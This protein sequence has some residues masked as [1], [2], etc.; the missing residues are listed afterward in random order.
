MN[1]LRLWKLM[2]LM[3]SCFV[4]YL[5]SFVHFRKTTM[6]MEILVNRTMYASCRQSIPAPIRPSSVVQMQGLTP[7]QCSWTGTRVAYLRCP[8]LTLKRTGSGKGPIQKEWR[9]QR[10]R[11]LM[12]RAWSLDSL[13]RT[14]T[15]V[16]RA[17]LLQFDTICSVSDLSSADCESSIRSLT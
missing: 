1:E 14:H 2:I 8:R 9:L 4:D 13:N 17:D 3:I 15:T 6:T 10:S 16:L 7:R 11:S 5:T 12:T